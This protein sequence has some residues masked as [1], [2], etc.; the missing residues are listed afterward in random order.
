MAHGTV[1]V[2]TIIFDQGGADQN[3]TV[4]GI[5]R[6]ITSG[7]TVSGTIAGAVLIGTT[8]VSGT[9]VTG[10]TAN[11]A[12]GVFTTQVSGA[13]VTGTQSS[14]TSGN[15]VTLSG[16]T[17]TFTSGVIASG[18]AAAPSL[19]ILGDPNTG[20]YSPGADQVAVA[21]NGTGRLFV[22][23]SGRVGIG[24]SS[25]EQ[26]LTVLDNSTS[27]AS[28][29][30]L[31]VNGGTFNTGGEGGS[32]AFSNTVKTGI[33]HAARIRSGL[34]FLDVQETGNLI[35]DTNGG[36]GLTERLRI[37]SAGLVGIGT[38][39]PAFA[40][41]ISASTDCVVRAR[42]NSSTS[43]GFIGSTNNGTNNWFFGSRKD[44]IG[45]N[46]GTDRFNLLY[47]TNA[48]LTVTTAGNVGIGTTSPGQSL[49]IVSPSTAQAIGIWNRASDNIY[50][51]IYFKTSDGATDQSSILNERAG[52]NGASLLF[53]TKADG[54]STTERL[55]ID[56]SGRLLVGTSSWSDRATSV[57]QGN[58]TDGATGP[59][60]LTLSR[61]LAPGSLGAGNSIGVVDFTANNAG[62][63]AQIVCEGD[64]ASG[65]NDYPGRLM[66]F[67]TAD[68]AASPTERMRITSAG[69]VGIGTTLPSRALE[70]N[71]NNGTN[72]TI[73]P[74]LRLK[75]GST[76]G[77]AGYGTGIE[78]TIQD[79]ANLEFV[80]AKI[81]SVYTDITNQF[82]DLRFSTNNATVLSERARIDSSGR[83]LVGTSTA[84]SLFFAGAGAALTQ[85]E[86]N[87]TA[88]ASLSIT[89]NDATADG[90]ALIL[91]KA[92]STAYAIL[93]YVNGTTSDDRI[94]R[95]SFQGADGTNMVP[96][97]NIEA[98]VDGTPGANDMP[99]RL[100]FS[101]TADGTSTPTERMRINQAGVAEFNK[102]GL[103]NTWLQV[104][105]GN[106]S[107]DLAFVSSDNAGNEWHF[108]RKRAD[109]YFYVV[110]QTGT[111]MYM[112]TN[113]WVATSDQRAKQNIAD[114][115]STID[116]VK[117]LKPSRFNWKT[118]G[119]ADV[120]FIAQQV[121]T[122][123]PEA[124]V[125]SGKPEAML[126]ITQ[127]KLLPFVV[128][129]LQ[130]AIAKIE[131][132]EARLIA[133][134][135]E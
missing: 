133:A 42:V 29:S 111:G 53:Y 134:G 132:L 44:T 61:G 75:T 99:G 78:F 84:R 124:V 37:T 93:Q 108:G 96:A 117:A 90:N 76:N 85:V 43:A 73:V 63:F 71:A 33:T 26:R 123:I 3:A 69:L 27:V 39:A 112:D 118:D 109:G 12:S 56:S 131:T 107:Q 1:K 82:G 32:I 129:A 66:F 68:G 6:A 122:L 67:T 91:A 119:T 36:A 128:K 28:G 34:V 94:G 16:A 62:S 17:A 98:F 49:S 13:T 14:F 80:S 38:S 8:T 22:D 46:S 30:T 83:L 106:S 45:G 95:I 47:D 7:V 74:A 105:N 101:T 19:S 4:S 120:G 114:I 127:D 70:I 125:D 50:S 11:F 115:E 100:V 5:Y 102:P 54:G 24:T 25:Q 126:G 18:T 103:L 59:G 57:L 113:S 79:S 2:D 116:A 60:Y 77:A 64:G 9:T 88:T 40:L 52:T 20:I 15:F 81:E 121:Q 51:G 104:Y 135:I 41:D 10:T 92:R 130:E 35:F 87:S 97:A 21:T 58:S 23:A 89:R 65:T 72:T 110:R 31:T 86:G 48:F 55:R